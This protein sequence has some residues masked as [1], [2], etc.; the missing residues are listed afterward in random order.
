M[1][2]NVTISEKQANLRDKVFAMMEKK[3]LKPAEISRITGRS[4][5][6]MSEFLNGK[7]SFSDKLLNAIHDSLKDYM[8]EDELVHT[9]QFNKMWGILTTGKQGCDMRLIAGNTGVGKSVLCKKFAEE[10]ECCYYVK[11]DRTDMSWNQFLKRVCREMGVSLDRNRKRF[12]TAF[13]L[14]SIVQKIEEKA[15]GNPQLIIDESE[16]ARNPFFKELK[17]L[18]TATEGLLS[19]VVVGIS[20]VVKRIGR[21]AGLESRVYQT[22][23]G[24]VYRWYPAKENSNIYTTFARRIKVFRINNVSTDDIR[25]FC[26]EKGIGNKKVI[27]LACQRWWNYED[28]DRA[29]K[30]AE[31]MNINLATIT[32]EEFEIL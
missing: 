12:S 30:R 9:R 22:P 20:D 2:K 1:E 31:R 18:Q 24:Y 28:A 13:L 5:G 27:E 32:T 16:F 23:S 8:G 25:A 26:T 6:T 19:I 17:G 3:N 10:N 11:I 4:E 14:D 29:V 7:K 15:D 21:L